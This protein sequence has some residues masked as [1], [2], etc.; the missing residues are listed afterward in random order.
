MPRAGAAACLALCAQFAPGHARLHQGQSPWP[1]GFE[2]VSTAPAPEL[3]GDLPALQDFKKDFIRRRNVELFDDVSSRIR[4]Y[5]DFRMVMGVWTRPYMK[6]YREVVRQTWMSQDQVCPLKDGPQD[7]CSIFTTF[8]MGTSGDGVTPL[9]G[10][11][12][13]YFDDARSEGDMMLLKTPETRRHAKALEFFYRS[14]LENPWATH[15]AKLD[16]QTYPLVPKLLNRMW[17]EKFCHHKYQMLGEPMKCNRTADNDCD[18][19]DFQS[20]QCRIADCR[21]M[22]RPFDY[23]AGPFIS[24]SRSLALESMHPSNSLLAKRVGLGVVEAEDRAIARN[25]LDWGF[26]SN[27]CIQAW[28]PI[29]MHHPLLRHDASF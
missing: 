28:D 23:I 11:P 29:A 19:P 24:L 12:L 8:V 14:A 21:Q 13:L 6:M 18:M 27:N 25:I 9:S 22:E 4:T 7:G 20:K 16:M 26:E 5:P 1:A 17:E 2:E 15:I 10:M 3:Y